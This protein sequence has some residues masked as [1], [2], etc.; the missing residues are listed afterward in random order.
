MLEEYMRGALLLSGLEKEHEKVKTIIR[1]LQFNQ[2]TDHSRG[3]IVFLG[4]G[5]SF[6]G[7]MCHDFTKVGNIVSIAPDSPSLLTCL[8]NDF[9]KEQMFV[10]WIKRIWKRED[11]LIAVSSSGES[12]NI[13]NAV[14]WVK[15]NTGGRVIT[16]T[17]FSK[18]NRL[19]QL[20]HV[21]VHLDTK[22]YGVHEC[23]AQIFLHSILDDIVKENN[24]T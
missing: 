18:E 24:A 7:H 14:K 17:G 4:N 11:I 22:S 15:E 13:I 8:I 19:N 2:P 3:R 21:N 12:D 23:Y 20:G 1:A 6:Q 9:P 16:I 5:G 10:E